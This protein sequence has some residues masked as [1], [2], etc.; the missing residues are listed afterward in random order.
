[1][2]TVADATDL[3]AA[4]PRL[5][6]TRT[7]AAAGAT[8]VSVLR[9]TARRHPGRTALEDAH[10]SLRYHELVARAEEVART[11]RASGV[12]PGERVGVRLP[13]GTVELYVAILGVLVSGAAYVPVDA[14]DPDERAAGLWERAD[15][16]CVL[17]P[18]GVRWRRPARGQPRDPTGADDAWVI[19]TSGSTGAPKAVAVSHAAATAFV[20]AESALFDVRPNDRVLGSLSVSFDASCEEMWLAWRH[21]ATLVA[22]PRAVTRAVDGLGEWL[23]RRRVT[24]VST[25]PTLAATWSEATLRGVRLLVLG[26]EVLPEALAWALAERTE[27]WNTYGPTEACV[28]STAARVQP[29]VPVRIGRALPGWTTA[30]VDAAGMA[31]PPGVAGEL[32]IGG[33]GLGRYLDPGLDMSGFAPHPALGGARTYRTGDLVREVAGELEFLGRRDEQVKV[34]GRRLEMGEVQAHL[35]SAPGVTAAAVV[36]RPTPGDGRVLAGYVTGTR[37][38]PAAVR[39]HALGRLPAGVPLV[40][41]VLDHLPVATAGKVDRERLPWPVPAS[42]A[43]S[44]AGLEG[45]QVWLAALWQEQLG[46]LPLSPDSDFFDCGGSSLS[47]ARLI[48]AVRERCPAAAVRDVYDH[49]PLAAL[50]TRL[51]TLEASADTGGPA[52]VSTTPRGSA[53]TL[54]VLGVAVLLV[55]TVV[56]YLSALLLLRWLQAGLAAPGLVTLGAACLLSAPPGRLGVLVASRWLLL[57]DLAPGRYDRHGQLAVRLWFVERLAEQCHLT[58]TGG[59]P[60]APAVARLLGAEVG[61]GAR[62]GT[63]PPATGLVRIGA[64][65]TVE[66]DVDLRGWWVR[67]PDLL[68]GRVRVAVGARVGARAL[69]L[70]GADVGA[71]AEVEPGAVVTGVV[72]AGARVAGT[73]ARTVGTAGESWPREAEPPMRL[74]A[75]WRLAYALGSLVPALP[76][77]A[78]LLAADAVLLLVGAPEGTMSQ[79]GVSLVAWAPPVTAAALAADAVVGGL[80]LRVLGRLVRSGYHRE[81]SPTAWAL[82]CHG[83]LAERLQAALFPLYASLLTRPW[84]RLRGVPVGRRAEV[85]TAVGLSRH[86]AIGP[87]S[88]L[89]D[90]IWL[91]TTRARDGWVHVRPVGVAAGA[92]LGNSAVISGGTQVAE[93]SLVGLLTTP[94][95][96]APAGTSWLGSPALELPRVREH[97]DPART[98]SPPPRLVAARA[99]MDTLRL[100]LPASVSAMLAGGL[101]VALDACGAGGRW[102]LAVA[103]AVPLLLLAGVTACAV[104]VAVKWLVIGRYRAGRHPLWSSFVWRDELVNSCQEQLA[105]PWLLHALIGTP[106]M[107]CYLRL[108]GARVGRD[109]HVETLAITEFDMVSLGDRVVLN[110]QACLETHLFHDRVMQI[111]PARLEDDVTLGPCSAVLPETHLGAGVVLGARS[112]VLRGERLPAGTTW[113]GVPV[114]AA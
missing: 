62:L 111:G 39:A 33:S 76:A 10:T 3:L 85:S 35:L 5:P 4:P 23:V 1:M 86:T 7:T 26:G 100:V 29:G 77:A 58:S 40:V 49:R 83:N 51:S 9:D 91:G 110:R 19:F 32:L 105:A 25:V 55:L 70:P 64:G 97:A 75:R 68:V 109:V 57:R 81:L 84:L 18:P 79:L 74:T 13:S 8:L 53:R 60:W 47:A 20:A 80:L 98:V 73:P 69:L 113:L 114:S 71:G 89:A 22:A 90:D 43:G 17:E 42:D 99:A 12:G 27:V 67:G 106:A 61:A 102:W 88:F 34:A 78:A 45:A 48:S 108:M 112:A 44:P 104:T 46:A 66:G 11:L 87:A 63:V 82:W 50:A 94:P 107:S 59:A 52:A 65:A 96:A 15:V 30:V 21:A 93:G 101:L 36:L 24:V 31:V 6:R 28:V 41:A 14:D 92:F 54:R 37:L 72:P 103:L 56:P 16:A 95:Q 38:D 2:T